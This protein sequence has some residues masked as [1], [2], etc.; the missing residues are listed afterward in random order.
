MECAVSH[1][2]GLV[3]REDPLHDFG[4]VGDDA[5][6]VQSEPAQELAL[7]R[8]TLDDHFVGQFDRLRGSIY[9]PG[10]QA[11]LRVTPMKGTHH[12]GIK[13]KL[14][15]RYIS[16]FRILAKHGYVA[17][18]LELP[19]KLSHVHDVFHVSQLHHCFKDPHRLVDHEMLKLQDDLSYKEHP[20]RILDQAECRTRQKVI[21]LLKV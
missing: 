14:A 5:Q 4:R 9:H 17:Y 8:L 3:L 10:E 15:P 21:K 11:Y 13:G 20:I 2:A 12:F 6:L 19:P 7:M 18:K 1:A 16:P